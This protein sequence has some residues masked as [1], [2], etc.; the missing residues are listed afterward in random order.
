M[1]KINPS[2]HDEQCAVFDWVRAKAA[3]DE[4]YKMVYAVPN[5]G[6]RHPAEAARMKRAGIK[7]GVSDIAVDIPSGPYHGLKIEMKV[8]GNRVTPVQADYLR[9]AAKYGYKTA[10]CWNADEAIKEIEGYIGGGK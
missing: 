2:E 9:L 4:R 5:G 6:S 10:V 8:T 7:A 3:H 1:R